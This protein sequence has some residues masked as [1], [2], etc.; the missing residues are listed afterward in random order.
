MLL[1]NQVPRL[2]TINAETLP[3]GKRGKAY[4]I[5]PG[6]NPAVEVPDAVCKGNKFVEL[7][8]KDGSLKVVTK[9]ASVEVPD[10][11]VE[12]GPYDDMDKSELKDYAET[13]GIDVKKSWGR[14][15]LIAEIEAVEAE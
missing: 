13:L 4:Q 1:K 11:E 15:K 14:P 6:N 8:I 2:I 12:P 7:L 5:K 10:E 9:A 3:N